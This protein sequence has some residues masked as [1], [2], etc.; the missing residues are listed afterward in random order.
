MNSI[1]EHLYLPWPSHRLT[2]EFS[3]VYGG[4]VEGFIWKSFIDLKWTKK[5]FFLLTANQDRSWSCGKKQTLE[6][7]C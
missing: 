1:W 5:V 3:V 4:V 6:E 2:S 7:A